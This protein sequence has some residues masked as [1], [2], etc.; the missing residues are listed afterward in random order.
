M[1]AGFGSASLGSANSNT[2]T[3]TGNSQGAGTSY[4]YVYGGYLQTSVYEGNISTGTVDGNTV[5]IAGRSTNKVVDGGFILTSCD[6][7]GSAVN[8]EVKNNIV[9]IQDAVTLT[10]G[11][12]LGGHSSAKGT[13][14]QT[15]AV[16]NNV[17]NISGSPDLTGTELYGGL[18]TI[19][20]TDS[21]TLGE[22]ADNVINISGTPTLTDAVLYGGYWKKTLNGTTTEGTGTGNTLNL[23][24]SG[25]TANNIKCFQNINFYLPATIA[26]G[27]SVLTLTDTAG[28]DI[29]GVNVQAKVSG[30]SS[31]SA[32]DTITLL[33]NANGLTATG[34]TYGKGTVTKGVSIDY[35]LTCQ[36]SGTALTATLT[37][38]ALKEQT[39]SFA[40]TRA[41][42]ASFLNSQG[43]MLSSS[44]IANAMSAAQAPGTAGSFT[45]FAAFGAAN[46]RANS[47]SYVDSHGVNL[48]VGFSRSLPQADG[49]LTYGP[50]V[51]YGRGNYD[52]YLNDGTHGSGDTHSFGV[53][54]FVRKDETSGI[55]YEGSLR[56]G[57][58]SSDYRG[59]LNS[60]TTEASYDTSSQYYALHMGLGR[61]VKISPADSV[62]VYGRYFFTRQNSTNADLSTG[63][64]YSFDAVNSSR[65]RLGSRYT[66]AANR[67]SIFYAGLA[68]EYEFAGDARA[69]YNG[70]STPSPSL[71][72]GSGFAELGWRVKPGQQSPMTFD[73]G[74][75]YWQG[76][77]EGLTLN[78]GLGWEF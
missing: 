68:Y 47:G 11:Y 17:I 56:A 33:T 5:T 46:M 30:A 63:E 50:L 66:H 9:N 41:G 74:L 64:H 69:A 19:K 32:G 51:E 65:L 3:V 49:T 48:N 6:S 10:Q 1:D 14:A 45:P 61:I 67:E 37:G 78:A 29:S 77:H 34:T 73:L 55:W 21:V 62:D 12:V 54:A 2:V 4:I 53:G 42:A 71:K 36:A 18:V 38:S 72:G 76:K 52:S 28:T 13:T 75:S 22:V 23:Y 44:G 25:L 31:L 70:M 20:G 27:D 26:N 39:K 8:G 43:D 24:T 15:G 35:D 59:L 58:I 60:G 57:R 40:E 7:S 16:S